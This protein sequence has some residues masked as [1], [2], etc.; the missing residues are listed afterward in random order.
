ML[1]HRTIKMFSGTG[2]PRPVPIF[3]SAIAL[4]LAAS[5]GTLQRYRA[6][7]KAPYPHESVLAVVAELKIFLDQDPYRLPPGRD[8]QNQNI[9]RVTLI[10][11]KTLEELSPA[12]YRDILLYARAECLERLG[13][14]PAA[15][16]AFADCA[17]SGTSLA[18]KSTERTAMAARM[19]QLTNRTA[20]AATMNG[21][22]NDLTVLQRAL[23]TWQ[24]ENPPFPY[25][26]LIRR[27]RELAQEEIVRLNFSHRLVQPGALEQ[28]VKALSDLLEENK[29]SSHYYDHWLLAGQL[30]ETLAT[31][32][33]ADVRPGGVAFA[34]AE[35]IWSKYVEQARQAY[36]QVAQAD[37]YSVKPEGQA[38]LRALEAYALRIKSEAK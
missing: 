19:R 21:Y 18:P 4:C 14:W 30:Y 16:K 33:T 32:L 29:E 27:E 26:S 7:V 35:K 13:D 12:E 31:D 24:S 22:L 37:G 20:M 15:E 11:L 17:A 38:R 8:L 2:R 6:P 5:C 25:P 28:A 3:L 23:Q 36:R 10:R 9:F 1:T 34:A